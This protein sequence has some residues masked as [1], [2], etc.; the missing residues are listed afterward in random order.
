MIQV[1]NREPDDVAFSLNIG[2]STVKKIILINLLISTLLFLAGVS[3]LVADDDFKNWLDEFRSDALL[4]GIS[5]E[6]LNDA[7]ADV[8][9]IRR[10]IEL[11]R[12]QP[13]GRQTFAE[14]LVR[15]VPGSR[16]EAAQK[17]L[18]KHRTL[19]EEVAAIYR[20]QPRFIVALWGIESDFGR[21]TGGFSVINA[22]ST[23][24]YDGRRSAF[25]RSQLIDA[26][27][28]LESED[29][30]VTGMTGSW[31]GAM[32]QTQF[33]PSSY[34]DF[35][36]DYDQDGRSDI[37]TSHP[38]IFASIAN[39]LLQ[40]NWKYDQTWGRQVLVPKDLDPKLVGLEITKPLNVWQEL[41]I[42]RMDGRDLPVRE[43]EAS[44]I[45]P[46]G[47]EGGSYIVYQNFRA[48][49]DWNRSTYFALSVGTLADRIT[50]R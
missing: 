3:S 17:R 18:A 44:L 10:I 35:A 22:L 26:L 16:V 39:Y 20:V 37:W 1:G 23:L 15:V 2:N 32:G 28:I 14:Y 4:S 21:Y 47:I 34:Q 42:R 6:T 12:N 30:G 36:V 27:R 40:A 19:L 29:I 49:L 11:D 33:M 31:A 24:A 7:F 9:L 50:G 25:F 48:I 38:D 43:L 8:R 13:E 41:G 46:N 45:M 5:E